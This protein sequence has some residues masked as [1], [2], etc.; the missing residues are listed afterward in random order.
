MKFRHV[1]AGAL[2]LALM[3][4]APL[5]AQVNSGTSPLTGKKGGT[6]NAFMQFAGPATS[7]KTFTLPNASGTVGVLN[8]IATWT[9]TQS[10]ADGTVVLLGSGSGSSTLKA[11][12][13]G[14]GTAT[15]F[16]GTDTI[17]G[18]N[19]T[20]TLANKS[21]TAPVITGAMTYGGVLL[22]AAVTGTGPM[23]LG[24]SPSVSGLTVTGSLTATGLVGVSALAAGT[25]DTMLG[26]F[27]STAA[28]ALAIANCTSANIY[29]TTTHSWS[30]NTLAGSGNVSTTG[31]PASGQVAQFTNATTI[32]GVPI[33]S[34]IAGSAGITVTNT[35]PTVTLSL[36]LASAV[37]NGSPANPA[38]GAGVPVTMMGLGV[39]TCRFAPVVSSRVEFTIEGSTSNNTGGSSSI[40]NIRYANNAVTAAPA[41][42]AAAVGTQLLGNSISFV[43]SGA[44]NP[45]FGF[46]LS[47]IATGLTVGATYWFDIALSASANTATISNLAC[48][49][50]EVL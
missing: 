1:L 23:V 31:T 10:F 35:L 14:G 34:F 5:H 13:T 17:V 30:C 36:S 6:N 44:T 45:S 48:T 16:P 33:S 25:Q 26:Y 41:N 24:I 8:A 11:P 22:S 39:T 9:A 32:Q 2:A 12:A 19:T 3:A 21:L 38:S 47:G 49:A 29:S 27:G 15:L 4:A 7:L 18:R 42:T 43:G 50:K 40:L 20:D 46:H 28:S 37:L